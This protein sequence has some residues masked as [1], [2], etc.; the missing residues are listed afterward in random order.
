MAA[1]QYLPY[2]MLLLDNQKTLVMANEA[3][4][5]LLDVEDKETA[6]GEQTSIV[7]QLWGKTLG[8]IGIDVL[9]NCTPVGVVWDIF[10]EAIASDM[11]TEEKPEAEKPEA[12]AE[13]EAATE[14]DTET[15]AEAQSR[16]RGTVPAAEPTEPL[17]RS[18]S[19]TG[20][21]RTRSSFN[22]TVI[23]V[24]ISPAEVSSSSFIRGEDRARKV[25]SLRHTYAK[26]IITIWG[27]DEGRYFMLTFTNTDTPHEAPKQRRPVSRSVKNQKKHSMQSAESRQPTDPAASILKHTSIYRRASIGPG[28]INPADI[29]ATDTLFPPLG[30]PSDTALS[31]ASSSL[32]RLFVMKDALLDSTEVPILAMWKDGGL[33][34]ANKAARKLFHTDA[35][36]A[37]VKTGHDVVRQWNAWDEAFTAPL[38]QEEHPI[39][40][41]IRTEQPYTSRIIGV[42]DSNGRRELLECSG[43]A[44][45]DEG[46][47]E[48]LAGMVTAKNITDVTE[49]IREIKAKDEQ[50]FQLICETMPQMIFTTAPNGDA[51]WFSERW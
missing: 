33:S 17:N 1:I 9:Q 34:I 4:G 46:T 50:R 2:P 42:V 40:E 15:E 8:Q 45:R 47:G 5:R 13:T 19:G 18:A 31:T 36:L 11:S 22:D 6:T 25:A 39:M 23:E 38:K 29:S 37:D 48:F 30:P 12:E 44:I 21:S 26:M 7:E 49:Q 14:A 43:E 35:K 41:L 51:E 28:I 27:Q 24:V 16:G 3:M 32:Q 20:G 10:L